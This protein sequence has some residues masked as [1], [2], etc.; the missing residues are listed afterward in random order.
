[1]CVPVYIL[2]YAACGMALGVALAGV[3]WARIAKG[4]RP[5]DTILP[6]DRDGPWS[7]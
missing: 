3:L 5:R 6:M 1:M 7:F 2:L 4:K